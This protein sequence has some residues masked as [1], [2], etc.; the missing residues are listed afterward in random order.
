MNNKDNKFVACSVCGI[1]YSKDF[2]GSTSCPSCREYDMPAEPLRSR[3]DNA[4]SIP[5]TGISSNW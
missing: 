3:N 1:K 4:M 2:F 5:Y